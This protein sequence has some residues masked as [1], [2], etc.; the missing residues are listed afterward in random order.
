[1]AVLLV[2]TIWRKSGETKIDTYVNLK[3]QYLRAIHRDY[4]KYLWWLIEVGIVERDNHY[5]EGKK[6]YGYRLKEKW[7][8][9]S[10]QLYQITKTK[11]INAHERQQSVALKGNTPSRNRE[12]TNT[13]RSK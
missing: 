9:S 13:S 6:S 11:T 1:M 7:R 10:T 8:K 12:D 3:G 4:Y 2:E 5:L